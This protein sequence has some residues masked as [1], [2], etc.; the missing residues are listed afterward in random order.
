MGRI[1]TGVGLISG[2]P[3]AQII[4]QLISLDSG[5]VTSLQKRMATASQQKDAYNGLL[6]QLGDLKSIGDTLTNPLTFQAASTASSNENVLTATAANGAAVGTFQFQVARLVSAQQAVSKGFADPNQTKIG[7]GTMTISQGGGELSSEANLSALN[8]G[9]GVR[10]GV[11]RI[12]D[13]AGHSAAIDI[14]SAVTLD[15]V[16]HK[17]N[18]SLDIDVQATVGRNGLVLTDRTGQ[19]SGNLIVHDLGDGHAAEDL[20]IVANVAGNTITGTSVN[21]IGRATA[22]AQLNDGR[23]IRTA[24]SG[25]DLRILA[26]DG[27]TFDVTLATAKTVGQ[28]LDLINA[29]GGGKIVADVAPGG[30][31]GI[32]L[33]DM[34]GGGGAITVAALNG[35]SAAADL[36]L[37]GTPT[38]G[39][40][41]GG[42]LIAALNSTLVS[43]LNGGAGIPLGQISITDRAGGSATINL[44]GLTS[45]QDIL[46]AINNSGA[47]VKASLN[48]SG[49]G[50]QLV[51][52]TGGSGSLQI[53]DVNS[54]TAAALGIAGIFDATVTAVNGAN[55]HRQYVTAN[56]LLRDYN[57]GKGVAPGKF[58]ITSSNGLQ[59]EIDLSS[60]NFVTVGDLIKTINSRGIGVTASIN[61]N[62]NGILLTDTAGGGTQ[63]KVEN[64]SG[65]PASDLNLLG[66]AALGVTTIDG[67]LEKTI[68]VDVNDTLNSVVTKINNLGFAVTA[69]VIN[70]GSGATPYRLSLTSTS[71]GR[72]GRFVFDGGTTGVGTTNLVNAQDAA[73]FLGGS[74]SAQPLLITSSTNQLT[75]VI[76]GVTVDLHNVSSDP[77]T[78]TV[79]RDGSGV[80]DQLKKFT[81]GFNAITKK[82]TDLTSFN[83][84]TNTP[85]LLLGESVAQSIETDLYA[86]YN[87]VVRN[88]GRY[89]LLTDVGV[90]IGDGARLSFDADKFTSAFATDPDA[91][92]NLFAQATTGLGT[93][94]TKQIEKL[95]D[96]EHGIIP[97]QTQ[98]IDTRNK[99]F[100]DRIDE[101]NALLQQKKE[102]LTKQFA[103]METVLANLQ[104]QQ[105]ALASIGSLSALSSAGSSSSSSSSSS[106][107]SSGS[108][109]SGSSTSRS[110]A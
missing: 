64:T 81:D 68:A 106:G 16:A 9:A 98:N 107:S 26:G 105:A 91:V 18:T 63:L 43:S 40:L 52:T 37:S 100:Q 89:K 27:S 35:S 2:I 44:A 33:T 60:G 12:T 93:F 21:S 97:L 32:R 62:G 19:T 78:L 99:D 67:A 51:D 54:T 34:T 57:G 24:A 72:D 92:K 53:A 55:L 101:L 104:S 103:N 11:F 75:S 79:S 58:R 10:R 61:A 73:V 84:K 3:S 108:S 96:P 45:V 48:V 88:A 4:D 31:T 42:P 29:A 80:S 95:T 69:S 5:P 20:G 39:T 85:G 15:D 70:D 23:G 41:N 56:T 14:S 102:R 22:L 38:I 77:V 66:T 76:K 28:V 110:G 83:T 1:S 25:A 47:G 49:N 90:K 30:G 36:G 74:G 94:I 109:G 82:L 50:I 59:T 86:I 13:R 7:A 8:G 71:T 46:D 6:S 87:G 17:I 65:T